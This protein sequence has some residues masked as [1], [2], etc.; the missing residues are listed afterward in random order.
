MEGWMGSI[1]G[2]VKQFFCLYG[3]EIES[4]DMEVLYKGRPYECSHGDIFRSLGLPKRPHQV[5]TV[6][7]WCLWGCFKFKRRVQQACRFQE[8]WCPS[9]CRRCLTFSGSTFSGSMCRSGC[10]PGSLAA[11][12]VLHS[13]SRFSG[14]A[15]RPTPCTFSYFGGILL[16]SFFSLIV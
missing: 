2:P 6:Q 11:E 15:M 3:R 13:W 1:S 8:H 12:V 7:E 4:M 14:V 9:G 5:L 10:V 16:I